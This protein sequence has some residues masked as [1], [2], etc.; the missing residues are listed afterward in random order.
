MYILYVYI[1]IDRNKI[2]I[3]FHSNKLTLHRAQSKEF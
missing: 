3:T 2:F 1:H